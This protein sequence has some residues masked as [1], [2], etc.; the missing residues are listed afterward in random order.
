MDFT[1]N[2]GIIPFSILARHAFIAE[3]LLDLVRLNILNN[4]DVEN[5][6]FNLETITS[7]FISDCT[8]TKN[9]LSFNKFKRIY[10]HLKLEL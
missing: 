9:L 6:K 2:Y 8:V 10:G 7:K 4:Y 1:I 5:F 3:N